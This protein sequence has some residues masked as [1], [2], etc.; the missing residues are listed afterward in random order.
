MLWREG[1]PGLSGQSL[2]RSALADGQFHWSIPPP[3]PQYPPHR[4]TYCPA[5]DNIMLSRTSE[6]CRSRVL[7]RR[8]SEC[9]AK[10]YAE[11]VALFPVDRDGYHW[12]PTPPAPPPPRRGGPL[13]P[14]T[15]RSR[16]CDRSVFG[17]GVLGW[18]L[19]KASTSSELD[20]RRRPVPLP[21]ARGNR[22]A[23]CWLQRLVRCSNA[24]VFQ[25]Y[26]F[27]LVF[28]FAA[29]HGF[30]SRLGSLAS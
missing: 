26:R 8:T 29:A 6:S 10:I 17:E 15:V 12:H 27:G 28:V 9:L 24:V 3:G 25:D 21:R 19:N 11:E 4:G 18:L 14:L 13:P 16:A 7:R 2:G 23:S 30:V 5:A 22:R 1:N 20:D